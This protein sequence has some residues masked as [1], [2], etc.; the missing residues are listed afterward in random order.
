MSEV[1]KPQVGISA[2]LLGA[3]VRFDGGHKK[4]AFVMDTCTMDFDLHPVCPEVELGLGIPRPAIQL[5][6]LH[7][8]RIRLVESK[9][10]D[11]DMT[12]L[13]QA[14][15]QRRCSALPAL[16]GYIFKKNSPRPHR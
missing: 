3:R 6:R 16:D 13:M 14:F 2:C 4:N 7:D 8:N 10:P 9:S 12:N 1:K 15:S 5:R 11:I